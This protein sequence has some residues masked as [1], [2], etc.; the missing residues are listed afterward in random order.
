MLFA[1]LYVPDF[2]VQAIARVNK[3]LRQQ[4]V[5]VLDRTPPLL[6]V[7][8]LDPKAR[9]QGVCLGMTKVQAELF[10]VKLR[11]RSL[12]QEAAAHQALLDCSFAFSPRVEDT[13]F[14]HVSSQANS[15]IANRI[16]ASSSGFAVTPLVRGYLHDSIG[17]TVILDIE[18][19]DRL[20]ASAQKIG[21]ALKQLASQLGLEV[22]VGIADNPEAATLAARGFSGVTLISAG[23][24]PER[25]GQLPIEILDLPPEQLETFRMWGIHTL[26]ALA[27]LPE[28]GLIERFGQEGK[29]LQ[30][31]ARGVDQRPLVPVEPELKFEESMELEESISF[32]EPLTFILGR[33]LNQ[34]CSR[35]VARSL[36][37]GEIRLELKLE[38]QFPVVQLNNENNTPAGE[39][40]AAL[41][42]QSTLRLPVPVQNSRTLL[43]LLQLDLQSRPPRAPIKNVRLTAEAARPRTL[44]GKLF[45]S[46]GPEPERMEITLARIGVLVGEN[47]AGSP[48]LR[49]THRP[50]AFQMKKFSLLEDS[51]VLKKSRRSLLKQCGSRSPIGNYP[52]PETIVDR[53]SAPTLVSPNCPR[54]AMRRFRPAIAALVDLK[55]AGPVSVTFLNQTRKV[56]GLA[57]PWRSSGDWWS[58][59]LWTR[60][61]WDVTLTSKPSQP[62][63]AA[64]SSISSNPETAVYRLYRDLQT[65][66]WFVEGVYD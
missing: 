22:N 62:S 14:R 38:P 32:L 23:S 57:G 7:I 2:P 35:L 29:R 15:L 37:A 65:Q 33:L 49:N 11:Q 53:R 5:A 45:S 9:Q 3:E 51:H 42:H 47:R 6:T 8:A 26:Q 30:T 58:E 61:E 12:A 64:S 48:V 41:F 39:T 34:L 55:N 63:Q 17:D 40:H 28:I 13:K 20:H 19:L 31:L 21:Q 10:D 16:G 36:A 1:C 60:D 50:D 66:K 59:S 24:E 25:L 56:V 46:Q 43:K 44:Q 52:R 4:A 27:A 18:G 54:S